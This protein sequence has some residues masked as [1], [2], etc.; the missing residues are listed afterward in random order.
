MRRRLTRSCPLEHLGLT[1]AYIK[2]LKG[3]LQLYKSWL[4]ST[5]NLVN[6]DA[7]AREVDP[8]LCKF[9]KWC[10]STSKPFHRVRG[11]ILGIQ[12][13]FGHLRHHIPQVWRLLLRWHFHRPWKPRTPF[14]EELVHYA[15]LICVNQAN[16]GPPAYSRTWTSLGV[17]TLLGFYG[18]LR[19]GES[20]RLRKMDISIIKRPAQPEVLVM[21]I[22]NPKTAH[23]PG[24]GRSQVSTLK[25]PGTIRW[26]ECL[27]AKLQPKDLLW[28]G[29]RRSHTVYFRKMV[30]LAGLTRLELTPASLRSGG[31]TMEFLSGTSM[32]ILAFKGRWTALPSLRAYLQEGASHLNWAKLP[33]FQA[34]AV[35][36]TLERYRTIL[37]A[38]PRSAR[39]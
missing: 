6:L 3:G 30:E 39:I 28:T 15:F 36:D 13:K 26:A 4:V 31:A 29:C 22:V 14:P 32:D 33:P 20:V 24:A 35:E 1:G 34:Q 19:P 11:A 5:M 7:E 37:L 17:I 2:S 21:S 16:C 27:L 23:V 10:F 18:L 25:D 38:P 12:T 8:L 9:V